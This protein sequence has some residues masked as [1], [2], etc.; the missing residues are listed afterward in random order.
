MI[1]RPTVPLVFAFL[2]ATVLAF[3]PAP[4]WCRSP[5]S[6]AKLVQMNKRALD[7]YDK[8]EWKSARRLLLKAIAEGNKSGLSS[9]PVMA[10]TF[11]HL[12]AV[13][14]VGL[15]DRDA[16]V[17][18]FLQALQIDPAIRV[19]SAMETPSIIAAFHDAQA[20][21]AGGGAG[22]PAPAAPAPAAPAPAIESGAGD[23][24]KNA[25]VG[26]AAPAAPAAPATPAAATVSPSRQPSAGGEPELPVSGAPLDCPNTDEVVREH[27]AVIRCVVAPTLK[28]FSV[29]LFFRSPGKEDF[30]TVE[31]KKTPKGWYLAE[32]PKGVT[33]GKSVQFY[34]EG[35]DRTGRPIVANGRSGSPN[36]MLVRDEGDAEV[37]DDSVVEREEN[38]FEERSGPR[39]VVRKTAGKKSREPRFPARRWWIGLGFGTGFGYAK[40]DG[41]EVRKDMQGLFNPG[42][43]WAGLGHLAPELGIHLSPRMA[44]SLQGREQWIQQSGTDKRGAS[45]ANAVLLR[46][47]FFSSPRALRVYAGPAVG[48][49]VFR[50]VFTP[51]P[52]DPG[53]KDS[54]RGGPYL[55]G[56]SLGLSY[57]LARAFSVNL[58]VK[59]LAGFPS[60]SVVGDLNLGFQV[61]FY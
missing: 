42:L 61:N 14:V 5:P 15:H 35:R 7:D 44:L 56:L 13:Y 30:A 55:G 46:L 32:I 20:K 33:G 57:A 40:G 43:G 28:V 18:C 34:V 2:V 52:A 50:F 21:L 53:A 51:D 10:R 31:M 45:G 39:A 16:G 27:A 49:G 17:R 12:G 25:P 60:F 22:S 19:A 24:E 8:L 1:Q 6:V 29:V 4:A 54:V 47:L 23:D 48:Y 3:V 36:L 37:P 41:L 59:G 38:P 11:L 9:H 26:T 58:E